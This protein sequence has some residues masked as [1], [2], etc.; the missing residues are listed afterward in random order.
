MSLYAAALILYAVMR[1]MMLGS[2]EGTVSVSLTDPLVLLLGV[3]VIGSALTLFANW[4]SRRT[5]I[6]TK[7]GIRF[8]NRF[9]ERTIPRSDIAQMLIGGEKRFKVRGAYRVVKIR[10]HSRRR[11]LRIRTSS[12]YDEHLMLEALES[13]KSSLQKP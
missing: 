5:V 7:D 4:Y 11:W 3:F 2:P 9:R 8:R 12:F 6:I 10:L 13:L 1:S